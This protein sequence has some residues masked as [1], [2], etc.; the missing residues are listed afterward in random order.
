MIFFLRNF[1]IRMWLSAGAGIP[2]AFL[3]FPGI[4]RLVPI[5]GLEPGLFAMLVVIILFF[6]TGFL[7]NLTGKAVIL[8]QLREAGKWE[9]AGLFQ[10]S[11]VCYLKALALFDSCLISLRHS[12]KT[13]R[14][15]TG[16]IA[17]FHLTFSSDNDHLNRASI[18]FLYKNPEKTELALLWVE[19]RF[20]SDDSP[21]MNQQEERLITRLA[22]KVSMEDPE[23]VRR[24]TA[25]FIQAK[26]ADYA[27][28]RVFAMA[29]D[30]ER[31]CTESVRDEIEELITTVADS[32]S[33]RAEHRETAKGVDEQFT[34][35]DTA[36]PSPA[37]P[38]TLQQETLRGRELAMQEEGF[39]DHFREEDNQRPFSGAG[40]YQGRRNR[41]NR[42]LFSPVKRIF[43]WVADLPDKLFTILKKIIGFILR[44]VLAAI[45]I[46][47]RIIQKLFNTISTNDA[48][49][50][51][52]KW[53][54][55]TA[56]L[57]GFT[58][59]IANTVSHLFK[60]PP[61]VPS[62]SPTVTIPAEEPEIPPQLPPMRFTIQA[63]AYLKKDH[64]EEFLDRLKKKGIT[65]WISQTEG[66]GKTWYLIRIEQ[67][68]TKADASKYGNAL[69]KKR[70]IDDYFVDNLDSEEK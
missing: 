26:R 48:A 68:Q 41:G 14:T 37:N 23:L 3:L 35:H 36:L 12:K 45:G 38:H 4:R 19:K 22:E 8:H 42:S 50:K 53:I 9:R 31:Q 70:I 66:G 57:I 49:R 25:I 60:R 54:I 62:S 32:R 47:I 10:K 59:F 21:P 63:S 58:V 34:H 13:A 46:S 17:R 39:A 1:S 69:K 56:L 28:R 24:L 52:V 5:P 2:I 18:S 33:I 6:L 61:I 30:N 29:L 64:A 11:E 65:A 55:L 27:A 51:T 40:S 16:A 44:I 7:M 20:D 67:F 15:L 43:L